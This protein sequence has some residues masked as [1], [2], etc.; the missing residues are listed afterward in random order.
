MNGF[1]RDFTIELNLSEGLMED[2]R[3]CQISP[4]LNIVQQIFINTVCSV[5][6]FIQLSGHVYSLTII[7]EQHISHP[8]G[9]YI[10]SGFDQFYVTF[11]HNLSA[12]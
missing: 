5:S 12:V 1:D 4:S 8:P 2:W 7:N 6:V 9:F 3:K 10:V 11:W